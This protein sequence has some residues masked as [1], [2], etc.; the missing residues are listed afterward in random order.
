[1]DDY[2]DL[3][4]VQDLKK[5]ESQD[6]PSTGEFEWTCVKE[7]EGSDVYQVSFSIV[8]TIVG[9]GIAAVPF[10][11]TVAGLKMAM[12]VNLFCIVSMM[13]ASHLYL[14]SAEKTG[15]WSFSELCY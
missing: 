1:M 9:G 12:M 5:V 2:V 8:S 11:M 3:E 4:K 7:E 15:L 14:K 13:F 10:A 6:S